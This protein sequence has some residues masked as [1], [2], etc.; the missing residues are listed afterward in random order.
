MKERIGCITNSDCESSE[1]K[2]IESPGEFFPCILGEDIVFFH[3]C[4]EGQLPFNDSP[5]HESSVQ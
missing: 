1:Y 2:E 4:I 3:E 5:K